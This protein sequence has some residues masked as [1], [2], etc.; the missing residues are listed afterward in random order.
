MNDR[1]TFHQEP[2]LLVTF[3]VMGARMGR[4][5]EAKAETGLTE[6]GQ[7]HGDPPAGK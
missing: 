7:A 4:H 5:A 3:R 1:P 6:Q 2:H